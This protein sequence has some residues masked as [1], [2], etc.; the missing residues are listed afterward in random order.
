MD[1]PTRWDVLLQL[2]FINNSYENN[3][4]IALVNDVHWDWIYFNPQSGFQAI[5]AIRK[6]P[7]CAIKANGLYNN[8][9]SSPKIQFSGIATN[10]GN[11]E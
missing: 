10:M 11:F 7:K 8:A 1:P 9:A 6:T 2:F 3:A 5:L 4:A